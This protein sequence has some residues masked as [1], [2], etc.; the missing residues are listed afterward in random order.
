MEESPLF[1]TLQD[2]YPLRLSEIKFDLQIIMETYLATNQKRIICSVPFPEGYPEND[3]FYIVSKKYA[4]K[5]LLNYIYCM[6][7]VKTVLKI[8][9]FMSS[10]CVR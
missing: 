5:Q 6:I 3:F 9:F 2:T 8:L 10:S 7:Q 1:I 4:E